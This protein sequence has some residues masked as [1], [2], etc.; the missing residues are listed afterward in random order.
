MPEN[1]QIYFWFSRGRSA[2]QIQGISTFINLTTCLKNNNPPATRVHV[3]QSIISDARYTSIDG[4]L[5]HSI[6]KRFIIN[7]RS[8]RNVQFSF[9]TKH[10]IE[11]ADCTRQR[12]NGKIAL[13]ELKVDCEHCEHMQEPR[14]CV[15]YVKCRERERKKIKFFYGFYDDLQS[16]KQKQSNLRVQH[17]NPFNALK[18]QKKENGQPLRDSQQLVSDK[19]N[20]KKW[21][22]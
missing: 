19:E 6:A 17:L 15:E 5:L 2:E 1:L 11:G 10:L 12:V 14:R 3:E 22:G 9:W 13:A 4:F 18:Q 7:F 20:G 8:M 16:P 21:I